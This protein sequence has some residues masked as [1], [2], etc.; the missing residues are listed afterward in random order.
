MKEKLRSSVLLEYIWNKDLSQELRAAFVSLLLHIHIDSKPRIE[1]VVPLKTKKFLLIEDKAQTKKL[2]QSNIFFPN[3]SAGNSNKTPETPLKKQEKHD[4]VLD[5]TKLS[6][7]T[8]TL[9]QL[10]ANEK[11]RKSELPEINDASSSRPLNKPEDIEEFF[12]DEESIDDKQ[13]K[14][15]KNNVIEFLEVEIFKK[16]KLT[17][18]VTI[19][20][21]KDKVLNRKENQEGKETVNF[22]VLLLNIVQMVRKMILCE[23]FT[24]Q[25]KKTESSSPQKNLLTF[26][27]K[28]KLTP[29]YNEFEKLIKSLII[30]LEY[31]PRI[32]KNK[33]LQTNKSKNTPGIVTNFFGKI[34]ITIQD[35]TETVKNVASNFGQIF[36]KDATVKTKKHKKKKRASFLKPDSVSNFFLSG[37]NVKKKFLKSLSQ[38]DG[39]NY[40]VIFISWD[41]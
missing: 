25:D 9:L 17:K 4:V 1:R 18:K 7:I 15:L 14:L 38:N 10:K 34:N 13:I 2:N 19:S 39:E 6:T 23:C 8:K 21:P 20:S 26:F 40:D 22:D 33:N 27:Q 28:T 36:F 32:L 5:V 31:Q 16:P 11:L 41:F 30:I 3:S 12:K 37:M 35:A 29:A 24:F